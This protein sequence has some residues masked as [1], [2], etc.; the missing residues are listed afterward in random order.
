MTTIE[1]QKFQIQKTEI[2]YLK[3]VGPKR[4]SILR[5]N[6]LLSIRDILKYFEMLRNLL[7][8]LELFRHLFT[9]FDIF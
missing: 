8:Y 9:D 7:N 4:G 2:N 3:G 6:G 5:K 1:D